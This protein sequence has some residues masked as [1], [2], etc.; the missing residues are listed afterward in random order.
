MKFLEFDICWK[1]EDFSP[2]GKLKE[3]EV[4][5]LLDCK[6]LASIKFIEKMPKL[7]QLYTLGTTIINDYDTTPAENIPVFFG[8]R[9][10][11]K[12]NKSYIEKEKK[13]EQ[14]TWSSYIKI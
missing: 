13:E 10:S 6:N 12:Y 7:Q 2:V 8:S 1:L 4:L 9:A 11:N 5:K 14:K 3:L